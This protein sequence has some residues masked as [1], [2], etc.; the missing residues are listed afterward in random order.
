MNFN[1]QKNVVFFV[2]IISL[3]VLLLQK[4][5]LAQIVP[6]TTLINNSNV[7]ISN[8]TNI[9]NGGTRAGSN[10]FHS[11]KE[12]SVS[13]GSETFFNNAVDIQNIISR[14]TG[15]SISSI[16]GFIRTNGTANL[17]LIN[18][19]GI[20]FGQNARLNIGGSFL[21]STANAIKFPNNLEFNAVNPQ[22]STLLSIN[23][24]IGLQFGKNPGAIQVSS[25]GTGLRTT[26]TL[27]DT[28]RA[29]RVKPNQTLALV[30]GDII[31]EGATLKTAGGRIELGSVS[32]ESLVDISPIIKGFALGYDTAQELGRIRLSRQ[33]S[34]DS[35]GEGSGDIQIRGQDIKIEGGSQIESGLLRQSDSIGI[36]K[37]SATDS[38]QITGTSPIEPGL[39]SAIGSTIYPEAKG[40]GASL[41]VDT[42]NLIIEEGAQIGSFAF[43]AGVPGDVVV[44][45]SD[46]I[47][48]NGASPIVPRIFS[49]LSIINS[50]ENS[51]GNITL[52]TGNLTIKDG[53]V[54]G[55]ANLG[56]GD[57]GNVSINASSIE[58]TGVTPIFSPSSLSNTA[59]SNGNA[60]ALYINT[61][62]FLITNGG[63]VSTSTLATGSAGNIFINASDSITVDGEAKTPGLSVRSS[64]SS[65]A[66][67]PSIPIQQT[68]GISPSTLGDSGEININT[69]LLRVVDGG[70]ISISN[71]GSGNAETLN[72]N[73][74]FI[75]LNNKSEITASTKLG[76]GGNIIINT[77]VIVGSN[78]S[79]I[80]ANAFQGRG[81]NITINTQAFVFSDDTQLE[82]SSQQGINGNVEVNSSLTKPELANIQPQ[83]PTSTPKITSVCPGR[84]G[85]VTGNFVV[86]GR[87]SAL[88]ELDNPLYNQAFLESSF[89][90]VE[91]NEPLAKTR[92][93]T[94]EE[95][96]QIVEA[97]GWVFDSNGQVMLVA[98]KPNKVTS[99]NSLNYSSCSSLTPI[100]QLFPSI[101]RN[102][103]QR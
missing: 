83:L 49:N 48:I 47:Q 31:L 19:N 21:G 5:A 87:E 23:L 34:V 78:N 103:L 41:R 92:S 80:T 55:I 40:T 46:S 33:A 12:F 63:A 90:S 96:T 66:A 29:L 54:V 50:S 44:N 42:R 27:I 67:V 79:R 86:R 77:E 82:A 100:S 25:D 22:S 51:G 72:I 57:V 97:Q 75:L 10:L 93:S 8:D 60:G 98:T 59:F 36:I 101:E 9:I 71:E 64:L 24:P 88:P 16:D 7:T 30:G 26:S 65:S 14:V 70:V 45:A 58:V 43:S 56:N 85:A 1:S 84:A 28:D 13:T 37:V 38:I 32:G 53:A 81:G 73:S 62:R 6:D 91:E 15:G 95:T 94:I 3:Y 17:F 35:S 20:I 11:F 89:L 99:D 68:V 74:K 52:S 69:N 2:K 18:P 76:N 39:R 61:E 102:K 4:S